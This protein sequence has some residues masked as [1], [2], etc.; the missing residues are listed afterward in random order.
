MNSWL[1]MLSKY[2]VNYLLFVSPETSA[3]FKCFLNKCLN[4]ILFLN[5]CYPIP[6]LP[7]T[8]PSLLSIGCYF[9]LIAYQQWCFCKRF[10]IEPRWVGQRLIANGMF[11]IKKYGISNVKPILKGIGCGKYRCNIS[12]HPSKNSW[13]LVTAKMPKLHNNDKALIKFWTDKTILLS[14]HSERSLTQRD[15]NLIYNRNSWCTEQKFTWDGLKIVIERILMDPIWFIRLK[16][17]WFVSR[18]KYMR[19]FRYCKSDCVSKHFSLVLGHW[20]L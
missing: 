15:P 8:S 5:K 4:N 20:N 6:I 14:W 11:T 18:L 2:S 7:F 19:S 16:S 12:D 10:I 13:M 17:D 9:C 3:I 1:H